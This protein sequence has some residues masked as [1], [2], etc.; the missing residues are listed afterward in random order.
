MIAKPSGESQEVLI[1]PHPGRKAIEEGRTFHAWWAVANDSVDGGGVG[2]VCLRGDDCE[3]VPL[4][5]P[6]GDCGTGAI[7]FGC[8]VAGFAQQHHARVREAI[9]HGA[10]FGIVDLRQRLR[11]LADDGREH[12]AA[13]IHFLL[14]HGERTNERAPRSGLSS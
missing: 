9:E 4:D 5:K 14:A 13:S 6:P 3:A 8:A 7:K 1:L 10:E 2:P 12:L 11:G